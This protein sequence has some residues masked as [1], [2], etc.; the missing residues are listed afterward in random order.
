MSSDEQLMLDKMCSIVLSE[1]GLP[2]LFSSLVK[3]KGSADILSR[4]N[5]L[6]KGAEVGDAK[7][8]QGLALWVDIEKPESP[9]DLLRM[10]I[11]SPDLAVTLEPT[12]PKSYQEILKN[13]GGV[14]YD[15]LGRVS[16]PSNPYVLLRIVE[17]P[18]NLK[19]AP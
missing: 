17:P 6:V 9:V 15:D 3:D 8:S 16:V 14:F 13:F 10:Q 7:F 12:L 11:F 5:D 18:L 19:G 1:G 2:Q 4:L